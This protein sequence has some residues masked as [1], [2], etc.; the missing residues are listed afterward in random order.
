MRITKTQSQ[1]VL[2]KLKESIQNN[3][4]RELSQVGRLKRNHPARFKNCTAIVRM[5]RQVGNEVL[6]LL[7]ANSKEVGFKIKLA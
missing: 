4:G 3:E 2:S 1:T 7:E 6:V 5:L